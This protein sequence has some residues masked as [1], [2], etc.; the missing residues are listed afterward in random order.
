M[1]DVGWPSPQPNAAPRH[2]T[3]PWTSLDWRDVPYLRESQVLATRLIEARPLDA[4]A[5]QPVDARGTDTTLPTYDRIPLSGKVMATVAAESEGYVTGKAPLTLPALESRD[6]FLLFDLGKVINGRP[7]LTVHGSP[8]TVVDIMCTPYILDN[9][10]SAKI[11]DS[12]LIDRVVLSGK[13]DR[14]EACY[15]KPTRYLGL[16]VRQAAGPTQI[17]VAAIRGVEYP[18]AE[19]GALH[20]PDDPWFAECWRAAARTIQVCTTDAYTDNYR[21][22]R[23]Y[24]QTG[25][26]GALGNYWVF[27]D[28]AL[29]RRYLRQVAQEQE[30]NGIMPAYAPRTGDDFMVI[31]DSNC[32]WIRSLRDYLLYSGD[33]ASTRGLLPA[34]RKLMRLLHSYTNHDGLLDRPPFA[35]WLDHARLDR[36]GA[37]FCLNGHYLG[38]IEDFAQVLDWL[39]EPDVEPFEARA[40][41]L[42]QSLREQFWVPRRQLFADALVDGKPSKMFSE[43]ANAMALAMNVASRE[44]AAAVARQLVARDRNDFVMRESEITMVTP[45]MSYALHVGLCRYGYVEDSLRVFRQRFDH[46]LSPDTNKTLWEEWWLDGTGRSGKLRKG[47][48]RSDAQTES[49]FPPAL[50]GEYLL[51]VR[52]TAPGF[53]EV[54]L[55]R[56]PSGLSHVAG[57]VPSPLGPLSVKWGRSESG[58][59]QLEVIVPHAMRVRLNAFSLALQPGST[60]VVDGRKLEIPLKPTSWID[61]FQ[62]HHV[63]QF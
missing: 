34:A 42:R 23:Q 1:R 62:G 15:F 28:T 21:E 49:A 47:K 3:P 55:F 63:I 16:V 61:L 36:R 27:G 6:W 35:Y 51:G 17:H 60:V 8:G 43:H 5:N 26:Y 40:K 11:F 22:R 44:Q 30:A 53:K 33:E 18:F 48:T 19:R 29:Q 56:S 14:W 58:G 31:L 38:A 52:P 9:R 46:M 50:F 24:A 37:N 41:A 57:T 2:L 54:E 39:D 20:T 12:E 10:F 32:L 13:R 4:S 59:N 7:Q 25:Y 45:A